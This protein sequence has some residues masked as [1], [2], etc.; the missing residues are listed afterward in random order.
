LSLL[1]LL[2]PLCL[3]PSPH[4]ARL[5]QQVVRRERTSVSFTR[6][7]VLPDNIKQDDISA[8]LDKGVLT[9]TLPKEEPTAKP[10]PRRITVQPAAAAAAAPDA[11]AAVDAAGAPTEEGKAQQE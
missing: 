1:L 11:A 3:C 2:L 5:L 10:Q 6:S 8:S 9:V 4:I 7:F